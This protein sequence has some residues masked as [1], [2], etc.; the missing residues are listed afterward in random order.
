MP[1]DLQAL[2]DELA[3]LLSS[4][5]TFE[6][7]NFN[8]VT[9]SSQ[10]GDLD[11]VRQQAILRRASSEQVRGWFEQFGIA[12]A[13]DP[14]RTPP[15]PEAGIV[16]RLCL[17]ARWRGVNYGYFWFLDERRQIN[18]ALLPLAMTVAARAGVALAQQWRTR[19]DVQLSVQALLS[20]HVDLAE[21][22][23]DDLEDLN[24]ISRGTPVVAVVCDLGTDSRQQTINTWRLPREALVTAAAGTLSAVVPL[25]D[26]LELSPAVDVATQ[27]RELAGERQGSHPTPV[28]I[29]LGAARPDVRQTRGSWLEAS[30]AA[31]VAGGGGSLVPITR[32][33]ELGVHRLLA[34][35]PRVA[36]REAVLDPSVQR[37][38][39]HPRDDLGATAITYLECAGN[40][41]KTAAELQVHRQ[42]LYYRLRRIEE[43]T[44]LDLSLGRDRLVL[45]LGL[46]LAA[47]LG[48]PSVKRRRL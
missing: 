20:P 9:F 38:L 48:A 27:I 16:A 2:V 23:A 4:A 19:Q 41:Q 24:V 37:L 11:Q 22:A 40:V 12:T 26:A 39:E 6:D 18:E 32:W 45:H 10:T 35:G 34:C 33:S 43:V 30:I 13:T 31:R 36:L 8:L 29:G 14:V 44:G 46:T 1:H 42:T 47:A 7:S 3:Q 17:P 28:T 21:Q 5:A 15:N 25:R